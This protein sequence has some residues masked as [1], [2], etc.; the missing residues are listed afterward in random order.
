MRSVVDHLNNLLFW[1]LRKKLTPRYFLRRAV[2]PERK[3]RVCHLVSDFEVGEVANEVLHTSNGLDPSDFTVGVLSLGSRGYPAQRVE[4]RV[5]T[6]ALHR[7]EPHGPATVWEAARELREYGIHLLHTHG[8]GALLVG[9]AAA[10]VAGIPHMVHSQYRLP[11][12]EEGGRLEAASASLSLS[13]VDQWVANTEVVAAGLRERLG[14]GE[15]QPCLVPRAVNTDLFRP[16]LERA[17]LR[18]NLGYDRGEIVLGA[19]GP[20]KPE[21]RMAWLLEAAAV[22]LADGFLVRVLVVGDGP[23]Q[24]ALHRLA[25]ELDLGSRC[26]FTGFVGDLPAILNA[27]DIFVQPASD[28]G[29]PMATLEAM[30]AGLPVVAAD[31]GAV[32][33]VIRAGET[34]LLFRP[35]GAEDLADRL[36]P[37]LGQPD[38]WLELGNNARQAVERRHKVNNVVARYWNL[39]RGMLGR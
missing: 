37:L 38:R 25:Q 26:Q 22:L 13:T 34:G 5:Q 29:V 1:Q 28:E 15:D 17:A 33:E 30:S 39:Y 32:G 10:R 3:V 24:A 7:E 9:A 6:W 16:P 20:L 14:L 18:G 35:G 8:W 21:R 12:E 36:R 27:M 4:P 19:V 23:E 11:P 31:E 2:D